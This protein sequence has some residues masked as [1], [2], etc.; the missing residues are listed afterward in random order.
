MFSQNQRY[1]QRELRM[2]VAFSWYFERC[3]VTLLAH[4]TVNEFLLLA[5]IFASGVATGAI[6]TWLLVSDKVGRRS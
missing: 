6:G 4:L 2:V 1:K 5:G 3:L